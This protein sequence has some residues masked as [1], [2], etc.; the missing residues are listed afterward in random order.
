VSWQSYH[1]DPCPPPIEP[2]PTLS[3]CV[4]LGDE[5]ILGALATAQG[6]QSM[7]APLPAGVPEN[8]VLTRLHTRYDKQTLSEDLVFKTARPLEGGRDNG[9]GGSGRGIGLGSL[10]GVNNFQARYIIRH[11]WTGK[12]QCDSPQWGMWGD[13]PR[14]P[15]RREKPSAA[16]GLANAARGKVVLADVVQT[17]VPSLGITGHKHRRGK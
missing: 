16:T 13:N 6:K 15:R 1:C 12:V 10:S 2:P 9:N 5:R 17:P 14:N 7:T 11:Y 3:D 4:T 8:G